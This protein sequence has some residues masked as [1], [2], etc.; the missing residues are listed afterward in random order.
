MNCSKGKKCAGMGEK[1]ECICLPV[2]SKTKREF[3]AM[4]LQEKQITIIG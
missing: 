1:H 3:T 2:L 4:H